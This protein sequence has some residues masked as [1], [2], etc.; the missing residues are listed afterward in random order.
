MSIFDRFKK[1]GEKTTKGSVAKQVTAVALDSSTTAAEV[2][3]KP[4]KK[5]VVKKSVA[6]K[7]SNRTLSAFAARTILAPVVS[8]KSAH[9]SD[10]SVMVFH[11]APDANRIAV[12]QALKE[13]YNVRALKINI[14]N[15]RGK[16]VRFGKSSGRQSDVKKALVTL[17]KGT[18]LDVFEGV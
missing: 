15:T 14:I 8:E 1:Q 3:S 4:T 17:P 16:A 12:R 11:V 2:T 7:A 18:R 5:T 6:Q 10:R 13:M 9:L